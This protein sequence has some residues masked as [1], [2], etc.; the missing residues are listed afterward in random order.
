MLNLD[1]FGLFGSYNPMSEESLTGRG[2]VPSGW[3]FRRPLIH[4]LDV[5]RRTL[6][7]ARASHTRSAP[8][9]IR[10]VCR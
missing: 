9:S 2:G 8:S 3:V 7:S 5:A 1:F 10:T 6:A 4:S